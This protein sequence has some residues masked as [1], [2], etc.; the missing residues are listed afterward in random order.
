[1]PLSGPRGSLAAR[2]RTITTAG[3]VPT[4]GWLFGSL[5]LGVVVIEALLS[6]FATLALGP[7]VQHL[8]QNAGHAL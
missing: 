3:T 7:M 5:P 6:F 2:R 4:D 8:L 1:M